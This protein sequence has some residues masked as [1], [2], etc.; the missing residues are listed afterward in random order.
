MKIECK[1]LLLPI[2]DPITYSVGDNGQMMH[3]DWSCLTI[4]S[5]LPKK[6]VSLQILISVFP[7]VEKAYAESP[8]GQYQRAV[9]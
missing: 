5:L 4:A 7:P 8:R 9:I 2:M 1:M 6:H 3:K